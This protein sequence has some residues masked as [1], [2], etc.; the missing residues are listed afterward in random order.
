LPSSGPALDAPEKAEWNERARQQQA[1]THNSYIADGTA[2]IVPNNLQEA[3]K[4]EED[5]EEAMPVK[6]RLM[7]TMK[8]VHR[9]TTESAE[10]NDA[11][12]HNVVESEANLVFFKFWKASD[13]VLAMLSKYVPAVDNCS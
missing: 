9:L 8:R 13:C 3:A 11:H 7:M 10:M 2:E 4:E 1:A 6:L 5:Q 12:K